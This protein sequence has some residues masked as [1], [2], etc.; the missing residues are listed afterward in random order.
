MKKS[1][2]AASLLFTSIYVVSCVSKSVKDE[3]QGRQPSSLDSY[4]TQFFN[5]DSL[6][7]EDVTYQQ[8][9]LNK[10]LGLLDADLA[11]F[12]QAYIQRKG[13]EKSG[14]EFKDQFVSAKDL[15]RPYSGFDLTDKSLKI[16]VEKMRDLISDISKGENVLANKYQIMQLARAIEQKY[17]VPTKVEFEALA[18]PVYLVRYLSSPSVD[19]K[20]SVEDESPAFLQAQLQNQTVSKNQNLYDYL[21]LDKTPEN[22]VYLKPKTGYGRRAGFQITCNGDIDYKVK[23]GVE[24]YSGPVNSRLYRAVGYTVPQINYIENLTM[25]YDRRMLVEFN[26]RQ[27]MLFKIRFAGVKV[28]ET[29]NKKI[30]DPFEM[31][32]YFE[33]KDGSLVSGADMRA[34]LIRDTRIIELAEVELKD[35]D[36]INQ[37]LEDQIK[38]IHYIPATL[39]VKNDPVMGEEIGHW[40]ATDLDYKDLKEVRAIVVMSAWIGNYDIRKDNLKL[41][42]VGE[43]KD[44]QIKLTI[45]DAGA[46]LGKGNLGFGGLL[47]ASEIND[48]KWTVSSRYT[49]HNTNERV[50]H[51]ERE[52]FTL[53]GL[54]IIEPNKGFKKIKISDGQWMLRRM[55]QISK[56]QLTEALVASGM[57]S[58]EVV[59]TREKLLFRRNKMLVDFMMPEN[60]VAACHVPADKKI[61]YDPA[62]D[63]AVKIYSQKQGREITAYVGVRKVVKGE[64]V[65]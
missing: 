4:V 56:N 59:L 29:T 19:P 21:A 23:F 44:A 15:K 27:K 65:P 58:A 14:L 30:F 17:T 48:M 6:A 5:T 45:G 16:A 20:A 36:F 13:D 39:T 49:V 12:Q 24:L 25:K 26:K 63:G 10:D 22:C 9:D 61:S 57:S 42:M 54:T 52:V 2:L 8:Y 11:K 46:G 32:K 62:K 38:T 7:N 43:G 28:R 31:I 47:S 18:F 53:D 41:N 50:N 37:D 40:S 3:P 34:K 1:I 64:L 35:T 51:D 33:L 60:E 55:C